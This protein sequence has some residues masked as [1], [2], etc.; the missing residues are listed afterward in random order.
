M[1]LAIQT[2]SA[3]EELN[4]IAQVLQRQAAHADVHPSQVSL[5]G[6]A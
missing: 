1:Q 2:A 4:I 5:Q 6:F 3:D